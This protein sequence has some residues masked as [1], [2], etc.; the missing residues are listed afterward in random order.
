MN[1][2]CEEMDIKTGDGATHAWSY[3]GGPGTRS[4][5][6]LYTDAFGV[7]PSMHEVAKRLSGLGYFVLLPNVFYRAGEYPSFD[8]KTVWS[9]AS[10]RERLMSLI[11]SLTPERVAT[12]GAAYLDTIAARP[13]VR[14]DRLGIVGYCMGG[15]MSF[16]T[17]GQHPERVRAAASFHGGGLVSDRPDGPSSGR[18]CPRFALLRR[19]GFRRE[20]HP[21][22]S[23]DAR[24]CSR[25]RTPRLPD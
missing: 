22:S 25:C 9:V 23:G 12:D 20:L 7:R 11:H 3:R 19:R 10:E 8:I 2:D 24:R 13:E 5:V 14:K 16:L 1:L 4:A 6:L 17:A 15:R 18:P 21:C